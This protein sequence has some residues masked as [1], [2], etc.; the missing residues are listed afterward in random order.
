M[1]C[2][3]HSGVLG[4]SLSLLHW[5][6][7]IHY[8]FG[9]PSQAW[10]QVCGQ[11]YQGLGQLLHDRDIT[12]FLGDC[13]RIPYYSE[14]IVIDRVGLNDNFIA[15]GAASN[16]TIIDYVFDQRSDLISLWTNPDATWFTEHHARIGSMNE[17]LYERAVLEGCV[18]IAGFDAGWTHTLWFGHPDSL[19]AGQITGGLQRIP[20]YA[21]YEI[22]HSGRTE[23]PSICLFAPPGG[24]PTRSRGISAISTY[25]PLRSSPHGGAYQSLGGRLLTVEDPSRWGYAP[26]PGQPGRPSVPDTE[27]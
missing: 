9:T 18:F 19:Y 13:G 7:S 16:E 15:R 12:I 1:D 27:G 2:W 22:A 6:S 3:Y 8:C 23:E 21:T 10:R 25:A 4:G 14:S 11:H 5:L 24:T 17:V 20:E 26:R